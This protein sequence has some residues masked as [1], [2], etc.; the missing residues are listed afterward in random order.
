MEDVGVLAGDAEMTG[1]RGLMGSVG[2]GERL[3]FGY[4]LGR[5]YELQAAAYLK[6]NTGFTLD[7]RSVA[8]IVGLNTRTKKLAFRT[9]TGSGRATTDFDIIVEFGNGDR[10]LVQVTR[11]ILTKDVDVIQAWDTKA[12]SYIRD[13]PLPNGNTW[14]RFWVCPNP[15]A[16][17][18][19]SREFR[20]FFRRPNEPNPNAGFLVPGGI[21][22]TR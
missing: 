21:P 12:A 1:L 13:T 8:R 3:Y 20:Y 15:E 4:R 19:G 22:T 16:L 2:A 6:R 14:R 5:L 18:E 9:S 7:G 10:G 17:D 11:N